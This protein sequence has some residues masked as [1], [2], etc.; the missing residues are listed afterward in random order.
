MREQALAGAGAFAS[1]LLMAAA[2]WA[3]VAWLAGHMP[4]VVALALGAAFGTLLYWAVLR[5]FSP[6]AARTIDRLLA[7][8]V[9]RDM[10]AVRAALVEGQGP[11]R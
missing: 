2:T 9:R 3:L 6:R 11:V 1:A 4:A 5:L 10:V 8:L 7:G